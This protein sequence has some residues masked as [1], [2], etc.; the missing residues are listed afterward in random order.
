M[1]RLSSIR[2]PNFIALPKVF[3]WAAIDS[4]VE[5]MEK[6]DEEI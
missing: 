5:E 1:L 3:L 2:V 4:K 6:E